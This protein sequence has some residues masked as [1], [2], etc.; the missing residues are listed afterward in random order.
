MSGYIFFLFISYPNENINVYDN[1]SHETMLINID[2]LYI[3]I[4]LSI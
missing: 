4:D 2:S 3:F 1:K